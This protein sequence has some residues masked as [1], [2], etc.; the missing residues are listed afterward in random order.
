M[1][2][3]GVKMGFGTDLLG[4]MHEDQLTEFGIRARV[5]PSIEILRQATSVNAEIL[6][7]TGKLGTVAPGAF[8]DLIVVDGNPVADLG[9][10]S[11]QGEHIVLVMKGGTTFKRP[12]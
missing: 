12:C 9:I 11:G 4:A 1:H 8:A 2:D 6:G 3:A 7:R 10:L 5:L